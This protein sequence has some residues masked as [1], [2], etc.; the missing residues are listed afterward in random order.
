MATWN[1]VPEEFGYSVT[2]T[3]DN[4]RVIRIGHQFGH[5]HG[6]LTSIGQHLK[7]GDVVCTPEGTS[8]VQKTERGAQGN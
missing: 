1:L 7:P 6:V 2:K 8:H 5:L 4:G 3:T